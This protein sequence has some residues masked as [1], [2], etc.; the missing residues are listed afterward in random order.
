MDRGQRS[1]TTSILSDQHADFKSLATHAE[2]LCHLEASAT[3]PLVLETCNTFPRLG[4]ADGNHIPSMSIT[5]SRPGLQGD[6]GQS[7]MQLRGS[8][9]SRI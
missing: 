1:T 4:R 8:Y 9:L 3:M 6:G 5:S 2:A 7:E